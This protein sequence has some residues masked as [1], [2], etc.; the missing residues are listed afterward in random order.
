[1]SDQTTGQKKTRREMLEAFLAQ[2]PDDAFAL[3]GLA[4]ECMNSGDVR[5]AEAHFRQLLE[6]AVSYVPAYLMFAQMLVRESRAEDARQV[7]DQGIRAAA[8]AGNAH[9]Q[10]EMEALL[11]EI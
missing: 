11:A 3:Y 8:R 6:P 5:S 2:K 1:M 7:L 9:A 4:L 10:S